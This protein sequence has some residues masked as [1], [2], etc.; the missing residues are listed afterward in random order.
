MSKRLIWKLLLAAPLSFTMSASAFAQDAASE[1][2]APETLATPPAKEK[3]VLGAD[4]CSGDCLEDTCCDRDWIWLAGTEAAFLSCNPHNSSTSVT[5]SSGAGTTSGGGGGGYDGMTYAPRVWL[6]VEGD[7]WGLLGR[8]FYLSDYSDSSAPF[9]G[10]GS[11]LTDQLRV[12]TTDLEF[13][14]KG[15]YNCTKLDAS[16]GVRY[17]SLDS[18]GSATALS[19]DIQTLGAAA[20]YS[21]SSFNGT[22][23]TGGLQGRT[24]INC[25]SNLHYFWNVRGSVIW[26]SS[27]ASA[28]TAA[29]ASDN[30]ANANSVNAAFA[31]SD[32]ESLWIGEIQ[33]GLQW[34]HQL[35]CIPA[36]AFFRV[37]AEYQNWNADNG[38]GAFATSLALTPGAGGAA[39]AQAGDIELD[40][41]GLTIGTGFTW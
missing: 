29:A 41:V 15:H 22:G 17:A 40:L 20:A 27:S 2:A 23:I 8:F 25:C 18:S 21:A 14:R 7:C 6:G 13:T 11:I 3:S 19:T 1:A 39:T 4:C 31:A 16:F 30:P 24:P 26:G 5:A 32:S 9:L 12:Y 28:I 10:N 34:E 36:N 33:V 38:S 37:A 35:T